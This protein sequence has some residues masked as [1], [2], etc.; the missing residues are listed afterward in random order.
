MKR[1]FK[2]NIPF[3]PVKIESYS[4]IFSSLV[5]TVLSGYKGD[6]V[7]A[8]ISAMDLA[9][10]FGLE[11]TEERLGWELVNNSVVQAIGDLLK[12]NQSSLNKYDENGFN[13][14]IKALKYE[15]EIKVDNAFFKSPKNS[16][17]VK[18]IQNS[19][20][21]W[22]EIAHIEAH[23]AETMA[24]RFPSF[25]VYALNVEWGKNPKKYERLLA[26]MTTPFS[27]QAIMEDDWNKYKAYLEMQTQESIFT[28][29]F[30]LSQI[31]I[32]LCAYHKEN[33]ENTE[34]T[35]VVNLHD[36]IDEWLNKED[37]DD[38]VRIISGGPGSGKSS[39]VK[40]FAAGISDTHRVLFIP[41]HRLNLDIGIKEGINE[42]LVTSKLFEKTPIG[43]ERKLLI[44]FDGLDELSMQGKIGVEAA[45]DFIS[46]L[47]R[48]LG[49]F[50]FLTHQL[51]IIITGRDLPVD[52]I[53]ADFSKK[54]RVLHVLPYYVKNG[55]LSLGSAED[56]EGKELLNEDKR[57]SWWKKYGELT[58]KKYKKLPKELNRDI[59][60]E[61]TGQPLL[62]YLLA[63]SYDRGKIKFSDNTNRNELYE[64]LIGAVYERGWDNRCQPVLKNIEKPEFEQVL[65]EIAVSAW[66]GAGRTATVG[67]IKKR[68]KN[69]Q[70]DHVLTK[71]QESAETGVL[72][73]LTAFYFRQSGKTSEGDKTFEFTHKSFGEYLTARRIVRQLQNTKKA[74]EMQEKEGIG[75]TKEI[76]LEK[77]I[78]L[79]GNVP[80][81]AD[82]HKFLC[83]EMLKHKQTEVKSWQDMLCELISYMLDF[84]MPFEKIPERPKYIEE[85]RQ[86]R[87]AE[88]ALLAAL[89][90]C[91]QFTNEISRIKWKNDKSAGEWLSKL[92]GQPGGSLVFIY[93]CLNNIDLSDCVLISKFF[94]RANLRGT[95]LSRANLRYANLMLADLRNADLSKAILTGADL[96]KAN[97][98]GANLGNVYNLFDARLLGTIFR[99]ND[100]DKNDLEKAAAKNA[101]II[102]QELFDDDL[103]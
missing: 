94:F 99:K 81:D 42:F 60:I 68:C 35:K 64:D 28:E 96:R 16:E 63:L 50:N 72:N 15:K 40:M 31:Y 62:N 97:L 56:V 70:I 91:S 30:S 79:C 101:I 53:E 2:D 55:F 51:S 57:N 88:E 24:A 1:N 74:I 103:L 14:K 4:A 71:F 76:A 87:N 6:F 84:G 69:S 8:V 19:L 102:E 59:L 41:L 21:E 3:R 49:N 93:S 90:A 39:F 66:Q 47:E 78:D 52:A 23:K 86:S 73:L 10:A 75:W 85:T 9:A 17:F 43:N 80:L 11:G 46:Q 5:K 18:D 7:E 38:S 65:E 67:A 22:F 20:R 54:W 95:D 25:F 36:A 98:S 44:I 32:P 45:R 37:K 61:I 34:K 26:Q 13:G 48:L 33:K 100:L 29:A 82:I 12:E 92:C 89:S 27:A 58:G 83:D 77:W